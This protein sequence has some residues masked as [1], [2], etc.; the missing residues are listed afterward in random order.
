MTRLASNAL[1]FW[2]FGLLALYVGAAVIVPWPYFLSL[3][4]I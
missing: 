4:H 2:F 1:V 3:I